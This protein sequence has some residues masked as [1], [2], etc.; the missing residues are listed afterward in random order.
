MSEETQKKFSD[1]DIAEDVLRRIQ[2][3]GIENPTPIQELC[4]G[5]ILAGRDVVGK[6]E[7]GTGKTLGFGAPLVN[8]IDTQRVATQALVL[9]PTRELAQQVAGVIEELG[10][11]RDL[12]VVLLVGGVHA[13]EQLLKL[14]SGSQIV[15]GTPGRVL[16]FLRERLLSLVWCE[17]VVLDE[18]D[19]MLDMGFI[20]DVTEILKR[21]PE[22]RQ[23]MLFSAT[24]P[25]EINKLLKSYMK[26]PEIFSTTRGVSAA[27]EIAQKYVETSFNNKFRELRKILDEYSDGPVII[28]CNTRRQTIDLDRMLWGNGYSAA[29]LHGDQEQDV[30]FKVL[31]TFRNGEVRILVCTDVASRGLD[32][33]E[34]SVSYTHLTLPTKA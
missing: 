31:E 3:M 8:K 18:A 16:D 4:I 25:P 23:T 9:T 1:F 14:R 11:D 30:R 34:V 24:V 5:P 17:T 15:V 26:D 19:R 20:D 22:E 29:A 7:T 21:T 13:S 2:D 6:A 33:D 12:G 27:E 32:I 10:V 28:F